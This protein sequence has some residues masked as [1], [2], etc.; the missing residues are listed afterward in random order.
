MEAYE[1]TKSF[2]S[3]WFGAILTIVAIVIIFVVAALE[4]ARE[5]RAS[6]SDSGRLLN[7]WRETSGLEDGFPEVKAVII[8]YKNK[9]YYFLVDEYDEMGNIVEWHWA[10]DGGINYIFEDYKYYVLVSVTFVFAIFVSLVNYNSTVEKAIGTEGFQKSLIYY[11]EQKTK[12]QPITHLIPMFCS[13]KNSQTLELVKRAIVEKADINWEHYKEEGFTTKNLERWQKKQI[14]KIRKIKVIRIDSSDL[15]QEKNFSTKKVRI[16]PEGQDEH[17]RN[18]LLK[19]AAS[20]LLTT[21]LSGLVGGFGIIIGN[22][23]L[24]LLFGGTIVISAIG[25]IIAG[26]DYGTHTLKNRFI[27]KGDLLIEF[28]N[29]REKFIQE[30][31]EMQQARELAKSKKK[32]DDKK[33][34]EPKKYPLMEVNKA[35]SQTHVVGLTTTQ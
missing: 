26:A 19:T 27:G 13:Y 3:A 9:E 2:L 35:S 20:K 4:G 24:G 10:Y 6:N 22:W 28:Y 29:L 33:Q 7:M 16:L 34:E 1:K 14:K 23:V 17:R 12:V 30:E 31:K 8:E 11:Q 18:F 15:L 5:V 32:N 25:A 21:A